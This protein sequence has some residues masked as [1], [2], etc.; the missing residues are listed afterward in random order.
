MHLCPARHAEAWQHHSAPATV[1]VRQGNAQALRCRGAAAS[2]ALECGARGPPSEL[3][4]GRCGATPKVGEFRIRAVERT[5]PPSGPLDATA[6]SE[7]GLL[8]C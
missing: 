8:V 7:L 4:A 1:V 3:S 5:A 2:R 6:K